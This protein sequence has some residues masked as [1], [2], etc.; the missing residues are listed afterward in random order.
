MV[1][2]V[3]RITTA[4]TWRG[5]PRRPRWDHSASGAVTGH[6]HVP[7]QGI[8][9]STLPLCQRRF[10]MPG[11]AGLADGT[12]AFNFG[13]IDLKGT[14][15]L[16]CVVKSN[17]TYC[18]GQ[19]DRPRPTN[20][21]R[22]VQRLLVLPDDHEQHG[23]RISKEV[24]ANGGQRLL[25][26][27]IPPAT[28]AAGATARFWIQDLA[29]IHGAEGGTTYTPAEGGGVEFHLRLPDRLLSELRE[30]RIVLRR[31]LRQP[32]GALSYLG[33]VVPPYGHPLF[34]DFR[35]DEWS[36]HPESNPG[37]LGV[38]SLSPLMRRDSATTRARTSSIRRCTRCSAISGTPTPTTR[39]R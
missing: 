3:R 26:D 32:T 16:W 7:K 18:V 23:R 28:I 20:R 5:S 31:E 15:T 17:G 13:V 37:L 33:N 12:A 25:R 19:C 34:V 8:P 22:P 24:T 39:P 2:A 35:V 1:K 30:R 38:S 29:G 36:A 21:V 11:G 10:R 4:A 27:R 9:N 6:T 14:P